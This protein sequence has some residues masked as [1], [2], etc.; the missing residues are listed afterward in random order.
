MPEV[1]QEDSDIKSA[2]EELLPSIHRVIEY[3][4]LN[5]HQALAL[6]CDVFLLMVRNHYIDELNSTEAGREYL[7]KCER[8]NT[9][10]IDIRG[11]IE[12]SRGEKNA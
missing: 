3:S 10:E 8:L 5:Y 1:A 4:G 12:F 2:G 7:E 9:T 11:I 6:P